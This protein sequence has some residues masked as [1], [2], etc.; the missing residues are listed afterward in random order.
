MVDPPLCQHAKTC[1]LCLTDRA[2][3]NATVEIWEDGAVYHLMSF[4]RQLTRLRMILGA[5]WEEI[6]D[7]GRSW[8]W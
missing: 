5:M 7:S 8:N 3:W 1:E 4:R 6:L 2:A